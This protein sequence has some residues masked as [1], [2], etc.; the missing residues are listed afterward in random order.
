MRVW[1]LPRMARQHHQPVDGT[2]THRCQNK[3]KSCIFRNGRERKEEKKTNKRTDSFVYSYRC[4]S[5]L[6]TID[7]KIFEWVRIIIIR[8]KKVWKKSILKRMFEKGRGKTAICKFAY[9]KHI[10]KL[11]FF[12][13]AV[14]W[15]LFLFF[16]KPFFHIRNSCAHL[17]IFFYV[18]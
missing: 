11:I 6:S 9:K 4:C 7:C 2:S 10:K 16:V 8:T 5:C 12:V 14:H 13:L 18:S 15:M 3:H 1:V 17:A